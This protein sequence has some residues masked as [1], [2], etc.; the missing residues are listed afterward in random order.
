MEYLPQSVQ[1]VADVIG[2]ER[3]LYLVG[4]LPRS[5]GNRERIFLY[6]PKKL[7]PDH[8]LVEILGWAHARMLVDEFGGI[9]LNL[10][11]CTCVYRVHR[12][13]HIR[14]MAVKEQKTPGQLAELF[15]MSARQIQNILAAKPETLPEGFAAAN[16][17]HR[18]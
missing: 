1:E 13:H 16:D 5:M 8:R 11:A 9:I 2:R 18:G 14:R 7:T 10:A 17:D 6:V 3:A 15:G 12:N 4:K